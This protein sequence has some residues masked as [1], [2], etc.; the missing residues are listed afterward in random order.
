MN[1]DQLYQ[2]MAQIQSHLDLGKWQ[3]L[4]LA[5]FS[6]G[7]MESRRCTLSIV[8]EGLGLLGKADSVERRLQ[9]WLANDAL[10][11]EDYQARWRNWLVQKVELNQML[12]ILVDET[13]L[14]DHM[15][16]MLVGLAYQ[17]RCLPLAWRCYA[18]KAW[19]EGQVELVTGLL[20]AVKATLPAEVAVVVEADRGIGTSPA[21]VRAVTEGLHWHYLFRVQG[22]THFQSDQQPDTELR[23]LT[24]RG[25]KAYRGTGQVF[26]SDGWLQAQVRVIWDA[27]YDEPW[28]LISDLPALSGREYAKRNWQ[29][30]AFRD[31]KSGGWHWNNSQ[32]W[33]PNHADRLLLVLSIAYVLT[34]S[35]GLR[36]QDQPELR[37]QVL[38]GRRQRYSWFRL[39]LRLM[40]ALKRL[41]EPI[42]FWFDFRPPP[43][44]QALSDW[45]S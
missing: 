3:S 15:S 29:E 17:Q 36:L 32:V 40:S 23:A 7:V 21:L 35:L 4:T 26:K 42:V 25:G 10:Q 44:L 13:K 2:W 41:A 8:S 31:L 14:S 12:T 24:T 11:R 16:I 19:P 33:Q 28:C 34:L 43:P 18:P 27:P 20:Q 22:I 5:A 6:L 9:R 30:Q 39:G 45:L 38:R 37:A 1:E